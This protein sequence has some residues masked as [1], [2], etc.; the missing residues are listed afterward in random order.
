MKFILFS[1][2]FG[3]PLN[4]EFKHD[5]RQSTREEYAPQSS[6]GAKLYEL[7]DYT[8]LGMPFIF[9]T[10]NYCTYNSIESSYLIP[11]NKITGRIL[12]EKKK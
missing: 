7:R 6:K 1:D 10:K 5:G 2:R 11:F 12:E 8:L 4:L 3:F 9:E